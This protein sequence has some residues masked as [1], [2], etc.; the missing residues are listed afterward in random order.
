ME[1]ARPY[2]TQTNG[3]T[4]ARRYTAYSMRVNDIGVCDRMTGRL[5]VPD[6][7]GWAFEN[8]LKELT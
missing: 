3:H 1:S 2:P 7:S 5:S 4:Y 8:D 6:L